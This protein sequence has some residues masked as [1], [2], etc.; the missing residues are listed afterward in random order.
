MIT[1]MLSAGLLSASVPPDSVAAPKL[2]SERVL[3]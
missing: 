1:R 2:L 3:C